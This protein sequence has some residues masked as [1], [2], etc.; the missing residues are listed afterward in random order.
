MIA[1]WEQGRTDIDRLIDQ[2]RL[3]KVV[4]SRELADL[5]I[6]R[7]RTHLQTAA[8]IAASDPTAAFQT[9]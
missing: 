9:A 7:A 3:Q 5:M 2:E 4:P 6:A 1:R 8:A